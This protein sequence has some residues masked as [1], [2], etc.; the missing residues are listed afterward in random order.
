[1]SSVTALKNILLQQCTGKVVRLNIQFEI[2]YG[3][4]VVEFS[5]TTALVV[6]MERCNF[7]SAGT[8]TIDCTETTGHFTLWTIYQGFPLDCQTYKFLLLDF[9]FVG[10][11]R[12]F[13]KSFPPKNL[14]Y[15]LLSYIYSWPHN[16]S[17]S[18]KIILAT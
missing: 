2:T 1:M 18:S 4:T 16:S 5:T 7:V 10:G 14:E 3:T 6:V 15:K 12:M 8:E 13:K 11:V 9:A 17:G